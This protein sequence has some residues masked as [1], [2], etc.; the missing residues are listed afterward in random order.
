MSDAFSS[1]KNKLPS[2]EARNKIQDLIVFYLHF[3]GL[4]VTCKGFGHIM[5]CMSKAPQHCPLSVVG[6]NSH[7][8]QTVVDWVWSLTFEAE[9]IELAGDVGDEV[10]GASAHV[11]FGDEV[12]NNAVEGLV[13]SFHSLRSQHVLPQEAP[14]WLPL[15]ALPGNTQQVEMKQNSSWSSWG[16][17]MPCLHFNIQAASLFFFFCLLFSSYYRLIWYIGSLPQMCRSFKIAFGVTVSSVCSWNECVTLTRSAVRSD[18]LWASCS[19]SRTRGQSAWG[20][21]LPASEPALWALDR[22]HELSGWDRSWPSTWARNAALLPPGTTERDW[23]CE[24]PAGCAMVGI[25]LDSSG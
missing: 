6:T 21:G 4:S 11:K 23:P 8:K 2:S 7:C 12:T 16:T 13:I 10:L 22:P 14:H 19:P 3:S 25:T 15:L 5:F 17:A 1:F 24:T 9:A 20:A 18:V